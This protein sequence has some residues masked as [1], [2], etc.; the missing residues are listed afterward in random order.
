[1]PVLG[2]AYSEFR[3]Y[4]PIYDSEISRISL[5]DGRGGEW[6]IVIPIPTASRDYR[7]SRERALDMLY[8][9][10]DLGRLPADLTSEFNSTPKV[11]S[12]DHGRT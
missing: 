12:V 7:D 9:A 10:Y 11:E 6:F 2:P 5:G 3:S 1:M 4:S 8:R